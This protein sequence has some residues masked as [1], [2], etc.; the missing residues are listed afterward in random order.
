MRDADFRHSDRA[1]GDGKGT[2]S[3]CAAAIVKFR[4]SE[5]NMELWLVWIV[6]N[7]ECSAAFVTGDAVKD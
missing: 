6:Q 2:C 3:A 1:V 7:A 5:E 4:K